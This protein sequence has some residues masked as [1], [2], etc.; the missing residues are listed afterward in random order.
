MASAD[1]LRR[2]REDESAFAFLYDM[3]RQQ[4]EQLAAEGR[5]P[6]FGGLLSKE[7]VAGVDTVRYEGLGNMLAGLLSPVA[8]A[9]DAP[10]S[11]YRG[12][13]PQEDMLNEAMNSAG[14]AS[15]L[16]GMFA[17]LPQ[18]ALA[19]NALR[20]DFVEPGKQFMRPMPDP[21]ND[22][23]APS[24]TVMAQRILDMR[25]DGR[26]SEVT[27]E[28]MTQADPAF[29]YNNTPLAMDAAA[30]ME[31][32]R[33]A[34]FDADGY[35]GTVVD[36]ASLKPSVMGKHGPGV[37]T[38]DGPE[39]AGDFAGKMYGKDEYLDGGKVLPMSIR[40]NPAPDEYRA[41]AEAL[42][43][44]AANPF[45]GAGEFTGYLDD[46]GFT[47]VKVGSEQTTVN[48][49]NMRSRFARFDPEF[50]HLRNL[51]SANASTSG[52]LLATATSN[53]ERMA[54]RILE[55][56]AA[57]RASEVT[58]EMMAQADPQYMFANT[59][60]PMDEAARAARAEA[61]G[62][63]GDLYHGTTHEFNQFGG[64]NTRNTQ[65]HF[66][67][68]DYFTDSAKDASDNYAGDGPDLTLRI[69]T[70]A[71]QI[72]D[73]MG[74]DYDD[75][76][77]IAAAKSELRGDTDGLII[78]SRIK[79]NEV[80]VMGHT[81]GEP[82]TLEMEMPSASQFE[83]DARA[84]LGPD[85]DKW[86][87]YD[88]AQ[89]MADDA[90]LYIEPAGPLADF[91][92]SIRSQGYRHD[93]DAEEALTP[94]YDDLADGAISAYDLDRKLRVGP[95]AYAE[96]PETGGLLGNDVIRQAF[97]DAGYDNIRMSANA[98]GWNMPIPEGTSHI[99]ASNPANIRSRFAR[100]D[101]EFAHLS[102]LN[103]ANASTVGGLLAQSGVS[104]KQ[105]EK[106]ETYLKKVGLL[107]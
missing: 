75:P 19:S 58:D 54:Q 40:S 85:A 97:A 8:R 103:A 67:A 44:S 26:A 100:F 76:A 9:A 65:G 14:L 31:R 77:A 99:I 98:Q 93:F 104:D 82:T 63:G 38:A 21:D 10:I 42:K 96:S 30:R 78:P 87:V 3:A 15:T 36:H 43:R 83:A 101:P 20:S 61:A 60:L 18:G 69:E 94:V 11:A 91:A 49:A 95:L 13:I 22:R 56:R 17:D 34:G 27:D 66:G 68:G 47:G 102:N 39:F 24:D 64:G 55:L 45:D 80:N 74:V 25:A 33:A 7:P 1:E 48:P 16:G 12:T 41:N 28:M 72:A 46:N 37:Y 70:R 32:A 81:R 105:A 92:E 84:E 107:Q 53:A 29:M 62:F 4:N 106:I 5:R 23:F 59:P 71:E 86:D 90:A 79:G 89:E 73:E 2:R 50:A 52:G 35:H 88:L 6:V 51:S 57:G